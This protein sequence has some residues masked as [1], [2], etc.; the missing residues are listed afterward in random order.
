M[1]EN[2]GAPNPGRNQKLN[3]D[4]AVCLP[5]GAP[6]VVCVIAASGGAGGDDLAI[7]FV[8]SC[9]SASVASF[10][11]GPARRRSHPLLYILWHLVVSVFVGVFFVFFLLFALCG[12]R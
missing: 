5:I 10:L 8:Y 7:L 9:F 4:L 3:D 12:V 11:T 6:I 2:D 1:K